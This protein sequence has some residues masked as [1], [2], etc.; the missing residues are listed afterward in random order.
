MENNYTGGMMFERAIVENSF[1][2]RIMFQRTT[3]AFAV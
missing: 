1:T 3:M 2:G